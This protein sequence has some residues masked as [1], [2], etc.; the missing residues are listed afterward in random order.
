MIGMHVLL[1]LI[2]ILFK[3]TYSKNTT[4]LQNRINLCDEEVLHVKE[5]GGIS[6]L[7]F[8]TQEMLTSWTGGQLRTYF[9]YLSMGISILVKAFYFISQLTLYSVFWPRQCWHPT[10]SYFCWSDT[11][12]MLP[13]TILWT[14]GEF[15]KMQKIKNLC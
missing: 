11:C 4:G 1:K 8:I 12:H 13:H 7:I 3:N 6:I 2:Y 5:T 9:V 14:V 10:T 15:C